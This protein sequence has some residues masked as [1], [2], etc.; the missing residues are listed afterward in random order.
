LSSGGLPIYIFEFDLDCVDDD[1]QPERYA[2]VFPI[3]W[4]NLAVAGITLWGYQQGHTWR[5]HT[6]LLRTDGRERPA[7]TWLKQYV[8][9][10][11][12]Q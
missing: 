1:A 3:L 11:E 9:T 10:S 8:A 4:N 6:Y 7:L 5:P 12:S 2:A